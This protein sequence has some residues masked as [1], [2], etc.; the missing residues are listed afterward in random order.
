MLSWYAVAK[1]LIEQI[2]RIGPP[3]VVQVVTDTCSVMKAAW[4]LV[5]TKFP[6]ITCTCCGPHVLNL[7]LKD[8]GKIEEVAAVIKNLTRSPTPS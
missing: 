4:K 5:E 7:Y 8:L 3:M 6:W 2:T 1:L